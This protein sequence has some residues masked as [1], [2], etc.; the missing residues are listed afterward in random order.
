M[1]KEDIARILKLIAA[2]ETM[3]DTYGSGRYNI[4]N[5]MESW[6][7]TFPEDDQRII[8]AYAEIR[9]AFMSYVVKKGIAKK[10]K[11]M[12]QRE[13]SQSS[14]LFDFKRLIDESLN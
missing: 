12:E 3:I 10:A 13:K 11:N 8:A 14:T 9:S 2:Y 4:R 6:V 7:K 5:I 1:D